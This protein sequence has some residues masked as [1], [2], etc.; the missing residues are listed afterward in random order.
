VR[1][2][3]RFV[4]QGAG[5][6]DAERIGTLLHVSYPTLMPAGYPADVL[7]GALPLMTRANSVLL[8]S[9]TYYLAEARDGALVG[10]GGWTFERPG[11]P[12]APIDPRLGHIR[13]FATHPGWLRH[14]A[15]RALFD[16]CVADART[17]GV[18][19]VECY[20]SLVAEPFYAA[21]GFAHV[22]PITI[23]VGPGIDFP[24]V[25]MICHLTGW[26]RATGTR[27]GCRMGRLST[28]HGGAPSE[29]S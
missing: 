24:C 16:R 29:R 13:H 9:G 7:A 12:G 3:E 18:Q 19:H 10:C 11:A 2:A 8:H 17:A 26:K 15:G 1:R 23:D 14:G 4:V 25:R 21:L 6:D 5:P 28:L 22:E 20:S 27:T